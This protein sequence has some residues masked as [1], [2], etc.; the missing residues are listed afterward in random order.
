VTHAEL[1]AGLMAAM[2]A[3]APLTPDQAIVCANAVLKDHPK[4]KKEFCDWFER[5]STYLLQRI[6]GA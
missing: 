2:K 5:H 6:N 4:E 1:Q 3:E